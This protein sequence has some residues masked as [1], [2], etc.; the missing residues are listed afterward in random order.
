MQILKPLKSRWQTL[1]SF[2]ILLALLVSA[3]GYF[4]WANRPF[5]L[6]QL[7]PVDTLTLVHTIKLPESGKTMAWNARGDLLA[8]AHTSP[9]SLAKGIVSIYSLDGICLRQLEIKFDDVGIVDKLEWHPTKDILAVSYRETFILWSA[10]GTI[11]KRIDNG[12]NSTYQNLL[13][14]Q[15]TNELAVV[16]YYSYTNNY[17]NQI[18]LF[19]EKGKLIRI[20]PQKFK[21]INAIEWSN[22][23]ILIINGY[24]AVYTFNITTGELQKL[25]ND[26]YYSIDIEAN[27][28]LIVGNLKADAEKLTIWQNSIIKTVPIS[29]FSGCTQAI[30]PDGNYTVLY[31]PSLFSILN[32][33]T[34]QIELYSTIE[35][36]HSST[37]EWHPSK[38]LLAVLTYDE[39][40]LWQLPE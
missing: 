33:R 8:V 28:N 15:N 40:Q 6:E 23:F 9:L 37:V 35:V 27:H 31:K 26:V 1:L 12:M 34:Q 7:T 21:L 14:N 29:G 3:A 13:W 22:K 18:T 38:P 25:I 5:T 39:I 10:D 17:Y 19:N 4:Y 30:S 32:H 11:I 36:D 20:L 16:E 2:G 24:D